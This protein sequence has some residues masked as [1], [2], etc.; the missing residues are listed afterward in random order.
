MKPVPLVLG[1]LVVAA[2]LAVAVLLYG[3]FGP[4]EVQSTLLGYEVVS[5]STVR[6]RFQ[7]DK[8]PAATVL[9]TVRA[10][11]RSGAEAGVALVRVGPAPDGRVEKTYD[12]V[13][14]ARA[15]SGEVLGCSPES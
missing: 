7:V 2:S 15:N 9:C 14:R 6:V 1:A 8:D 12:L 10:R 11:E 3:R 13:T 4:G 5:D